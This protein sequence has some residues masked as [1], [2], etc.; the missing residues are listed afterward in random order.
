MDDAE[1]AAAALAVARD[2]ATYLSRVLSLVAV[3]VRDEDAATLAAAAVTATTAAAAAAVPSDADTLLPALTAFAAGTAATLCVCRRSMDGAPTGGA[4]TLALLPDATPAVL[5]SV[6]PVAMVVR[7]AGGGSLSA[8]RPWAAQVA[9]VPCLTATA[10][11][12]SL[13]AATAA[14]TTP[15]SDGGGDAALLVALQRYMAQVVAPALG[16]AMAP[17]PAPD[18]KRTAAG[19]EVRK[20]LTAVGDA[21]GRLAR[22]VPVFAVDL[23]PPEPVAALLAASGGGR[24]WRGALEG[25]VR[26]A[27]AAEPA[28]VPA[29]RE[30]LEAWRAA[31]QALLKQLEDK[32]KEE[33]AAM[34]SA[35]AP[36][37]QALLEWWPAMARALDATTGELDE[38]APLMVAMYAA[39]G[40]T[41]GIVWANFRTVCQRLTNDRTLRDA[42]AQRAAAAADLTP[43][44]AALASLLPAAG[45]P[46]PASDATL[47][48]LAAALAR[49]PTAVAAAQRGSPAPFLA[50]VLPSM[51]ATLHT[52][53]LAASPWTVLL[54]D[55]ADTAPAALTL[56][57]VVSEDGVA[58]MKAL[59]DALDRGTL[60]PGADLVTMH[61]LAVRC[62]DVVAAGVR[63]RALVGYLTTF[64]RAAVLSSGGGSG[65]GDDSADRAG[66][67]RVGDQ[68]RRLPEAFEEFRAALRV[69]QGESGVPV[70][71]DATAAGVAAYDT[72]M[73][74]LAGAQAAAE[75]QL[76]EAAAKAMTVAVASASRAL[77]TLHTPPAEGGAATSLSR[78]PPPAPPA[79]AA[80]RSLLR[81]LRELQ[82][83]MAGLPKV[84]A[85]LRQPQSAALALVEARVKSLELRTAPHKFRDAPEWR[86]TAA[87]G[88]TVVGA[89]MQWRAMTAYAAADAAG[90]VE[91]IM[92]MPASRIVGGGGG[93]CA[94]SDPTLA[95]AARIL[96]ATRCVTA[97]ASTLDVFNRWRDPITSGVLTHFTSKGVPTSLISRQY[98]VGARVL[99]VVVRN[100]VSVAQWAAAGAAGD[101]GRR[102]PPVTLP[103]ANADPALRNLALPHLPV[104]VRSDVAHLA[105]ARGGAA[106]DGGDAAEGTLAVVASLPS[107]SGGGIVVA[108]HADFSHHLP[109]MLRDF[110]VVR[111]LTTTSAGA[112]QVGASAATLLP[113]SRPTDAQLSGAWASDDLRMRLVHLQTLVESRYPIVLALAAALNELNHAE[114]AAA[115]AA[116]GELPAALATPRPL[117]PSVEAAYGAC[118]DALLAPTRATC[119]RVLA[120]AFE[121]NAGGTGMALSWLSS[122][123]SRT[124]GFRRD[125][126]VAV[127]SHAAAVSTLGAALTS[128][129]AALSQVAACPFTR[130]GLAAAVAD[131][132]AALAPLARH[133]AAGVAQLCHAVSCTVHATVARRLAAELAAL[134]EGDTA[135]PRSEPPLPAVLTFAADAG[136]DGGVVTLTPPLPSLRAQ[137]YGVVTSLLE[138]AAAMLL[139]TL[140]VSGAQPPPPPST[141]GRA[142]LVP[143]PG[144]AADP[145]VRTLVPAAYAVAERVV[146]GVAGHV[147]RWQRYLALLNTPA[148]AI[149]DELLALPAVAPPATAAATAP[150]PPQSPFL[151]PSRPHRSAATPAPTPA[152]AANM[153]PPPAASPSAGAVP[154]SPPPSAGAAY[155]ARWQGVLAELAATLAAITSGATTTVEG[156][157]SLAVAVAAAGVAGGMRDRLRDTIAAVARSYDRVLQGAAREVTARLQEWRGSVESA[158]LKPGSG[159]GD[160]GDGA[161]PLPELAP[162]T[163]LVVLKRAADAV[164]GSLNGV[165]EALTA[166]A[167]HGAPTLGAAAVVLRRGGVALRARREAGAAAGVD[168]ALD[169]MEDEAGRLL[170]LLVRRR[171]DAARNLPVL[172][173]A[174][175]AAAAALT[176]Q[177]TAAVAKWASRPAPGGGTDVAAAEGACAA[178]QDGAA[179]LVRAAADLRDCV[180][181]LAGVAVVARRLEGGG[182]SAAAAAA[183]EHRIPSATVVDG[184]EGDARAH[185]AAV[186]HAA[187]VWSALAAPAAALAALGA[188]PLSNV[189]ARTLRAALAEVKAQ[190]DAVP[191]T[192]APEDAAVTALAA[193]AAAWRD[194]CGIVAELRAPTLQ[195]RH[196]ESV[197]L[198]LRLELSPAPLGSSAASAAAGGDAWAGT[199]VTLGSLMA[200]NLKKHEG[201]LREIGRAAAGE[202]A[203]ASFLA[204]VDRHWE[205]AAFE[206]VDF[207]G[208]GR[209]VRGWDEVLAA[210][211]DHLAS[212]A[213]LKASPYYPPFEGHAAGWEVRIAALRTLVDVWADVQRRWQYLDGLL[214][215]DA[216]T[217]SDIRAQLPDEAH[218]FDAVARELDAV[219]ARVARDHTVMA[220]LLAA[221]DAGWGGGSSSDGGGGGEDASSGG[222]GRSEGMRH[223]AEQLRTAPMGN[224]QAQLLRV[225]DTLDRVQRGLQ[226][227]LGSMRAAF[228]RLFFLG[229]DDCL[230]MLGAAAA[231]PRT[232]DA[233]A[234]ARHLPAMFAGVASLAVSPRAGGGGGAGVTALVSPEGEVLRLAAPVAVTAST[235][236][237]QWLGAVAA[238]MRA[239]LAASTVA[240]AASLAAAVEAATRTAA[241]AGGAVTGDAGGLR[242]GYLALLAPGQDADGA[243]AT[244]QAAALALWAHWTAATARAIP[245]GDSALAGVAADVIATL[246]GVAAALQSAYGAGSAGGGSSATGGGARKLENA[247][248]DLVHKRDVTAALRAARV[249][250]AEAF[251]WT[252]RL[253]LVLPPGG[254]GSGR[255]GTPPP[256]RVL[257]CLATLEHGC[258]YAG[259]G[260]RLVQT[261]LTDRAYL[262][263]TQALALRLGGSPFGPAGTGKTETVKA[264]GGTLGRLVLVFCC[265]DTFDYS[266]IGRI[267]AGL[268]ESGA[269]GCFDEFNR[270]QA[271]VLS[272]ISQQI[273][274]IQT[275]L[276]SRDEFCDLAGRR[277]RLHEDVGIFVTMNPGYAGRTALPD[278][279]KA[280]FRPVAMVAPDSRLIAEVLLVTQGFVHAGPLARRITTLFPACADQLSRQPHYDF[281]LRALKTVLVTAG[282]LRR[283]GAGGPPASTLEAE[284]RVACA[285]VADSVAPKLVPADVSTFD[286]LLDGAFPEAAGAATVNGGLAAAIAAVCRRRAL[287]V[288]PPDAPPLPPALTTMTFPLAP[289]ADAAAGAASY[290]HLTSARVRTAGG[291]AAGTPLN[292]WGVK[293]AQL[294]SAAAVRHGL[295]LVGPAGCGKSTALRVLTDALTLLDGVRNDVVV[296]DPKACP[297]GARAGSFK[298]QLF[299]HLDAASLEW[300]DGLFTATLR[301]IVEGARGEAARRHWLVLDGDIDPEWV[302]NL[303]SVLDDNRLLTLPNGERIP[304]PPNVRIVLEVDSLAHATMATVSRCGMVCFPPAAVTPRMLLTRTAALLRD[305]HLPRA[306]GGVSIPDDAK[307]LGGG[308]GTSAGA[309]AGGMLVGEAGAEVARTRHLRAMADAL[310][311]SSSGGGGGGVAHDSPFALLEGVA[312]GLEWLAARV[313]G[314]AAGGAAATAQAA[315][316]EEL[317]SAAGRALRAA[318]GTAA[319]DGFWAPI[320]PV[321]ARTLVASVVA[322][323]VARVHRA[324]VSGAAQPPHARL[325]A[326][327]LV[328]MVWGCGAAFS[329]DARTAIAKAVAGLAG[330]AGLPVPTVGG[331]AAAAGGGATLADLDLD[332]R[333]GEVS[334]WSAAVPLLTPEPAAVLNTSL[335]VP[336]VD[337]VRHARQLAAWLHGGTPIVLCGPPGSGKT[338]VLTSV[339]ASGAAGADVAAVTI[340]FSSDTTPA[341][342]LST[343]EAHCEYVRAPEGV[344]LQ[345]RRSAVSSGGGSGGG[346]GGEDEEGAL[347][348][349]GVAGQPL[350]VVFCD[351]VNLPAPD[352]YGTPRV[353]AFLRQLVERR[354]FWAP[355]RFAGAAAPCRLPPAL[356]AGADRVWVSLRGVQFVGA[357]NPPTDAGR[358]ALPP[359][360]LRHAPVLQVG[361]PSPHALSH[362]Y[363]TL[364]TALCKLHPALRPLGSPL[365]AASLQVYAACAAAFSPAT[366]PQYVY[367]PRELSRWSRAM[368]EALRP[369]VVAGDTPSATSVARLWLHEGTRLFVDRC[370]SSRDAAR[371]TSFLEAAVAAH[372]APV[373]EDATAVTAGPVLFADWTSRWYASASLPDLRRHVEARLRVFREEV[374]D[375]PLVVFDDALAH[376]LRIDRV[377]Q[378]PVGHLLLVGAAGAGKSVLTRFV[379]WMRGMRLFTINMTPAY[380]V[381]EFDDD[382]RAVMRAAGVE[383]ERIVFLFDES[384]VVSSAFLERMNA[385]LAAGDIPGLF[386]ADATAGVV[387][388]CQKAWGGSDEGRRLDLGD[389]DAV[390]AA[391]VR[392]VQRNLHIVFTINP[393]SPAFA[394]RRAT[395]PALFNRCVVDWFGD[396]PAAALCQVAG[397]ALADLDLAP[398]PGGEGGSGGWRMPPALAASTAAEGVRLRSRLTAAAAATR[399]Q[400]GNEG[401]TGAGS[402]TGAGAGAR[403]T[404]SRAAAAATA[405]PAVPVAPALEY[406][407]AVV[408]AA[409][410]MHDAV[411]A[412]LAGGGCNTVSTAVSPR[413]FL[414]LLAHFTALY[415]ARRA[416]IE[417]RQLHLG[418]GLKQIRTTA[419]VV[420]GARE[421]LA[422]KQR[423]LADKNEAAETKLGL[424]VREQR[425]AEDRR[426]ASL[427]LSR[428]LAAQ[429]SEIEAR[430][431]EVTTQLAEAEPALAGAK[432]ALQAVNRR[433]LDEMRAMLSPPTGVRLTL[434]AVLVATGAEPSTLEWAEVRRQIRGADFLSNLL[435]FRPESLTPRARAA[436]EERYMRG[437]AKDFNLERVRAASAACGSLYLWVTSQ[438]R[439]AEILERVSPLRGA[440]DAL[441]AKREALAAQVKETDDTV[442]SLEGSIARYKAEY[443][444]LI[445]E[446]EALRAEMAGVSSKVERAAALV[447][448]LA[449][450]RARWEVATA[451]FATQL[452]SLPSDCLLGAAFLAYAGAFD[453]RGRRLL[454]AEWRATLVGLGIPAAPDAGGSRV[455]GGGEGAPSVIVDILVTPADR[456][457]WAAAGVPADE[458]SLGNA[459]LLTH[460]R[461]FPLIVDPTSAALTFLPALLAHRAAT[462]G[463][464]NGAG[465]ARRDGGRNLAR[466]S[467]MDGGYLKALESACR[468]GTPLLLTDADTVHPLLFPVLNR[469]AGRVSA[470]GRAVVVVGGHEVDLSPTFNLMLFS[471]DA[472]VVYSADVAS[473]VTLV[474]F[475][476]STPSLTASLLTRLLDAE[477]P[478]LSTRRKEVLASQAAADARLQTLEEALLDQIAGAGGDGVGG[479]HGSILDDDRVLQSLEALKREATTIEADLAAGRA[480]LAELA[481][482]AACYAPVAA[483]VAATF[484]HLQSMAAAHCALYV[485][486]LPQLL[487]AVEDG[488]AAHGGAEG[489]AAAGVGVSLDRVARLAV[490]LLGGLAAPFAA[491]MY[492]DHALLWQCLLVQQLLLTLAD[493]LGAATGAGESVGGGGCRPVDIPELA[494]LRAAAAA[495]SHPG[496]TSATGAA[497]TACGILPAT[498]AGSGA[499]SGGVPGWQRQL[500]ASIAADSAA[501][502]G[503][504]AA[505]REGGVSAGGGSGE[506][507][508]RWANADDDLRRLLVAVAAA[509]GRSAEGSAAVAAAARA[510][511]AANRAVA[512]VRGLRRAAVAAALRPD[513]AGREIA[514][515][516][517]AALAPPPKA[518]AADGGDAAALA[519]GASDGAGLAALLRH[520]CAAAPLVPLMLLAA[521]GAD[522]EARM[523]AAYTAALTAG[524][525]DA[526]GLPS[527][528]RAVSMGA[529][530]SEAAANTALA[531]AARDGSWLLL[532]NVH[533]TPEWFAA[534]F[535]RVSSAT[536]P[537]HPAFRLIVTVE[538]PATAGECGGGRFAA[539]LPPARSCVKLL[540]ATPTG[541]P[542]SLR[543]LVAMLPPP[544]GEEEEE[545]KEGGDGV[546]P[547]RAA[548]LLAYLHALVLERRRFTPIGWTKAYDTADADFAAAM[549]VADR[550]LV[551]GAPAGAALGTLRGLL[552]DVVYGGRV[553]AAA[554]ARL[555]TALVHHALAEGAGG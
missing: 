223:T 319:G 307:P 395:S 400:R 244:A 290:A 502:A 287:C 72:I 528:L 195:R 238:G 255:G 277:V 68:L 125:V 493:V 146:G 193:R 171:G 410:V 446:V 44:F 499:G 266:A 380:G 95:T 2:L 434:E 328:A 103:A 448:S 454:E 543:R 386:D 6:A 367:S 24:D 343:L 496:G 500:A 508:G 166:V 109:R 441:T 396:W 541:L 318:A 157:G 495:A 50:A 325:Q 305:G 517:G 120:A 92:G 383:G 131:V 352:A 378:Q 538:V 124:A 243:L 268:A 207:R 35:D 432:A 521:P 148:D 379:A 364:F 292:S 269:W 187:R 81:L 278:N 142:A 76:A 398:P 345:P 93:D 421:S 186:A 83:A 300:T 279:L 390:W 156:A 45:T 234:L 177:L 459:A 236:A 347:P 242:A 34:V 198:R 429:T 252:S 4:S 531:A 503:W 167:P 340:S 85:A 547:A 455:A 150:A 14:A 245:R 9:V 424:M 70:L 297:V 84:A 211:D 313:A 258:E 197:A 417:T 56:L 295:I 253:R 71:V 101:G 235:T 273:L 309:G 532:R 350:L 489:E 513:A 215:A 545:E 377:L 306:V 548:P 358:T 42:A 30:Q 530:Q 248:L 121:T 304:L 55:D 18:A 473:R 339:L 322:M 552:A 409:T 376:L 487:A 88:T 196:V 214:A 436:V 464:S 122:D 388:E 314:D 359:R 227:Y 176:A 260:E 316:G 137:L 414:D 10:A 212:L 254:G 113:S 456:L 544:V 264:L 334:P 60:P 218:T 491:G 32:L 200:T 415:R 474:N 130:D 408:A 22:A 506:P 12:S 73:S 540:L 256:P 362:I 514:R 228:P 332:L 498:L 465:G 249:S 138:A 160:G 89:I 172:A 428:Q 363:G 175:E 354:G 78:T 291:D 486:D 26:T 518:G 333:T 183:A 512:I 165:A 442:T 535:K 246:D 280:L 507:D 154:P 490:R 149:C 344:V 418:A 49:V 233:S 170:Q 178:A 250:D 38:A 453:Y 145:S 397:A 407:D 8:S 117:P 445:R 222:G 272:A 381:A 522:T 440:L 28:L 216:A 298:E 144:A 66:G 311:G 308:G 509:R 525:D 536:A 201:A 331:A 374:A 31:I 385:L 516:V 36:A 65:G 387:G 469:D 372:L 475:A 413:D 63:H 136:P 259:V 485:F 341:T 327:A 190:C 382:L 48:A 247:I 389:A 457:A 74:R 1:A 329:V 482:T 184:L 342:V 135:A 480:V 133:G 534:V 546:T 405:Q 526:A 373:V 147:T 203:V 505:G 360:F 321:T 271:R 58:A 108:L 338:L 335:V 239:A 422:A 251:E 284:V 533:L 375:I 294:F 426:R 289:L 349:S 241:A 451:G 391:F 185:A 61:K 460:F 452:A 303:N 478:R 402:G 206:L 433:E 511:V 439:Y 501:W 369:P 226:N 98:A 262:A 529:A 20:Q 368:Y 199:G 324:V 99:A 301:G 159:G 336:T 181:A 282:A 115:R 549:A 326:W 366:A 179:R 263:L 553:E 173:A 449:S 51:A 39:A 126:G 106:G 90:M 46:P 180:T 356:A 102:P 265:D 209:V 470:G 182:G 47:A 555:L 105:A 128:L 240:A 423:V 140:P 107:S 29:V 337:T 221:P 230:E 174:A 288:T 208:R 116:V 351:E 420:A 419:V 163:P 492:E 41:A 435:A 7:L 497:L 232:A 104:W 134:V 537:P 447:G 231:V 261:P 472:G 189:V 330:S 270:L 37:L 520:S 519:T 393:A 494:L 100:D 132:S 79:S 370:G 25:K 62:A 462:A 431:A 276:A 67:G 515:L 210:A 164:V 471:R 481:D 320:M 94:L 392:A 488:L 57:R 129:R 437:Q 346:V 5:A 357:C 296:L 27:A 542:A 524:G 411:A 237:P 399:R 355:R 406:S 64:Q 317:D 77:R 371:A 15:L 384:N 430:S 224:M 213:A 188:T 23:S 539:I 523:S 283:G 527:Q 168:A 353:I 257:Q 110:A 80:T 123:T 152:S 143:P 3:G 162:L 229:D 21:L 69:R 550:V 82:P 310:A 438:V 467:C 404:R 202:A 403:T 225:G 463:G 401:G 468:F 348:A 479:S 267:L 461:R 477:A 299:G 194:A 394:A 155:H 205:A 554:D 151:T 153:S 97:G 13:A 416:A 425:E 169:D 59:A 33:A 217:S 19:M 361:Y 75:A 86:V 458:V 17:A 54:A 323:A 219:V 220:C 285:A 443:A 16:A 510:G 204:G 444:E 281:G 302:E 161:A 112:V 450:E 466:A 427:E 315:G 483:G 484:A 141:L 275:S 87:R 139:P 312:R 158:P 91:A 504:V 119:Q 476:V 114:A 551:P 286:A 53:L 191:R 127:A 11:P 52:A 412:A 274:A 118:V 96:E 111:A 365:A 293:V 192:G 40:T 43:P